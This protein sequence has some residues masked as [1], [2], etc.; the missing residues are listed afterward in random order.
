[1]GGLGA[2]SAGTLGF[3]VAAEL[4]QG[5]RW[6]RYGLFPTGGP[7]PAAGV[8]SPSLSFPSGSLPEAEGGSRTG[9]PVFVGGRTPGVAGRR[10]PGSPAIRI[11]ALRVSP[12]VRPPVARV[13][14]RVDLELGHGARVRPAVPTPLYAGEVSSLEKP[15]QCMFHSVLERPPPLRDPLERICTGPWGS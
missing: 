8:S 6:V 11:S 5:G 9:R 13:S 10:R 12:A 4:R 15:P 14:R 3:G 1:M 7:G 2:G